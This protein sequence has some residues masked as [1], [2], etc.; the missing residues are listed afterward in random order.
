MVNK[1]I[2]VQNRK[3]IILRI[4]MQVGE[5][6]TFSIYVQ[7]YLS[8]NV[9]RNSDC[10][11]SGCRR[12]SPV[13]PSKCRVVPTFGHGSFL[14]NPFQLVIYQSLPS[15]GIQPE[16]LTGSQTN[17]KDSLCYDFTLNVKI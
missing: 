9:G 14:P 4:S 10:T 13:T 2:P 6:M 5:L 7:E 16:S 11:D 8:S 17:H 15:D 1:I 3:R 12:N